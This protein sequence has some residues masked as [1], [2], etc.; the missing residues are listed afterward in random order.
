MTE[1]PEHLLRRSRERRAALGLG[2]DGEGGGE[3]ESSGSALAAKSEAAPAK[4][5]AASA[6]K[7]PAVVVE[8]VE[9]APAAY[10]APPKGPHKLRIPIWVMPVLIAIPLWA[11]FFPAAFS[12]HKK[13][14]VTDPVVLGN[15][16][17]HSSCSTCHGSNGEGGV[18]PAL[19][20]GV[21]AITFP[22]VADHI[23][24]VKNGST[25]LAKNAPYGDPNREGGQRVASKNDMPGFASSLS[26]TQ[27]ADVVAYE[28]TKL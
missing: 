20:G 12:N 28:R 18:G 7:V 14:A 2:G 10:I 21:A 26:P 27:I 6:A 4:A 17:Y 1:I 23:D 16:V 19:H 22:K 13:A 9:V 8:P 3:S 15:Q 5:P 25:G 11:F 24:W